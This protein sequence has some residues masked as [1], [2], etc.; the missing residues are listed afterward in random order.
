MSD[1]TDKSDDDKRERKAYGE[2]TR[3][4]EMPRVEIPE[5]Q[6]PR[7]PQRPL[8]LPHVINRDDE[9]STGYMPPVRDVPDDAEPR[10]QD[11]PTGK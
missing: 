7:E 9:P 2:I 4:G 6:A 1:R 8:T 5:P 3:T 11:S 10:D